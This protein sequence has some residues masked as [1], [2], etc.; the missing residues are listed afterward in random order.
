[1]F[2]FWAHLSQYL[3]KKALQEPLFKGM[4]LHALT[5]KNFYK[6]H[7]EAPHFTHPNHIPLFARKEQEYFINFD[8]IK[9][10]ARKS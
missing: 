4:G 6:V 1:M 9:T 10:D 2:T 5:K 8:L 3:H 7:L